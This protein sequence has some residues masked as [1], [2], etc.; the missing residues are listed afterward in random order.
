MKKKYR[1]WTGVVI[2]VFALIGVILGLYV[3]GWLMFVKPILAACALLDSG[4]LTGGIL[5][6]T[7]IKCLLASVVGW[8]V[9]YV[10]ALIGTIIASIIES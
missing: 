3:G 2:L 9:F 10:T 7:I 8:I 1:D 4:M 5:G 6:M